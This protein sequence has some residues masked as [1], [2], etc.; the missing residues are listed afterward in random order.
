MGQ[1]LAP[2][3]MERIPTIMAPAKLSEYD[4]GAI[5]SRLCHISST[6]GL[7]SYI[8]ADAANSEDEETSKQ[9]QN[10]LLEIHNTINFGIIGIYETL[11]IDPPLGISRIH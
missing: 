4:L 7:L 9:A 1:L 10:I 6:L 5:A 2:S 8:M 3:F 11:D